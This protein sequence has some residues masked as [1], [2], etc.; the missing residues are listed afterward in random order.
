MFV[1]PVEA[2]PLLQSLRT[3]HFKAHKWSQDERNITTVLKLKTAA[4][5]K[6]SNKFLLFY[7]LA[8][9]LE[10]QCIYIF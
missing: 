3:P 8:C 2:G 4:L 6:A 5:A 9:C 10:L 1:S 7:V